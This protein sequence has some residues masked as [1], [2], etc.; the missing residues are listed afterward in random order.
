MQIIA[1]DRGHRWEKRAVIGDSTQV[2]LLA[3]LPSCHSLLPRRGV[4][5]LF[6]EFLRWNECM[7]CRLSWAFWEDCLHTRVRIFISPLCQD[8]VSA[9]PLQRSQQFCIILCYWV[10]KSVEFGE[11]LPSPV[12]FTANLHQF[13]FICN[14]TCVLISVFLTLLFSVCLS[15]GSEL[16]EKMGCYLLSFLAAQQL[17]VAFFTGRPLFQG[18]LSWSFF[19]VT[20]LIS[21]YSQK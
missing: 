11:L 1:L 6:R 18:W 19:Y 12:G 2:I 17:V 20:F 10:G 21:V 15:I 5:Y 7:R 8:T 3:A 9:V 14:K 13:S 16:E 4:T